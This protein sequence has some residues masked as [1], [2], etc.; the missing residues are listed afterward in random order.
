MEV[1]WAMTLIRVLLLAGLLV[2]LGACWESPEDD[3]KTQTAAAAAVVAT[4]C[5]C[6]PGSTYNFSSGKCCGSEHPYYYPGTHG[7]S[8]GCYASCPYV[9]DCGSR[10]QQ[11]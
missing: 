6:A 1:F 9:G 11:C 4:S 8:P 3:T 7:G 5:P 10:F 2:A